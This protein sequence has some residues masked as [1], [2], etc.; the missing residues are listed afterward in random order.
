[1][2]RKNET[3]EEKY[4]LKS[5]FASVGVMEDVSPERELQQIG[6]HTMPYSHT[7]LRQGVLKGLGIW[8]HE[9]SENVVLTGCVTPFYL[10][11]TLPNYFQLLYLLGIDFKILD[12]EH[13]CGAYATYRVSPDKRPEFL[14]QLK[15][16][17]QRNIDEAKAQGAKN[18]YYYC[19]SCLPQAQ[20]FFDKDDFPVRYGLDILIE[21][22]KKAKLKA[23]PATVG[24][25]RGCWRR[26]REIN[27]DLKLSFDSYRSW[28][29]S[30]EGI[31]VV[32]IEADNICCTKNPEAIFRKA[33]AANVDYMVTPCNGCY[34]KLTMESLNVGGANSV[35]TKPLYEF[36]LESLQS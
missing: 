23:E 20:L 34:G 13:C 21:P 32:D 31:K 15:P 30:V 18:I 35:P 1:M 29:G 12:E 36:L 16:M 19:Y 2:S 28:V 26:L 8:G 11:F 24:Y 25:Y 9:N 5:Y 33:K 27:P 7:Q 22:M 10:G 17:M 3:I 14:E 6:E 4:N